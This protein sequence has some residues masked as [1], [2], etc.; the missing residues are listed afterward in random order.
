MSPGT[1][2][3]RLPPLSRMYSNGI[4]RSVATGV[5]VARTT[6]AGSWSYV[7]MCEKCR[8]AGDSAS[9]NRRPNS[10]SPV[11]MSARSSDVTRTPGGAF[12][13]SASGSGAGT[14][15]EGSHLVSTSARF[16]VGAVTEAIRRARQSSQEAAAG[17]VLRA[18]GRRATGGTCGLD[19][20]R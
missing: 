7:S 12:R 2:R 15:P 8:I 11:S 4:R 3:P 10:G 9:Q 20:R 16:P 6:H 19:S 5:K 13:C 17:S 1:I 14:V 18:E